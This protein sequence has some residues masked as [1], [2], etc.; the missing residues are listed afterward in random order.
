MNKI[1]EKYITDGYKVRWEYIETIP[2]FVKLKDC[3]QNP[4]WHS[5][6]TAWDHTQACVSAAYTL[7]DNEYKALTDI[8]KRVLLTSVLF[9]DIGKGETTEFTK[10]NWHSYGHEII[11][12][13]VAR[14][15]LWEE[16]FG[17]RER[18][19]AMVRWHMEVLRVAESKDY[20]TK[21][22]KMSCNFFF[23][24]RSAIFVKKCDS[25]GS[26][27]DDNSVS[28][29]D[30]AKLDFLK[31]ACILLNCYEQRLFSTID[32]RKL[33]GKQVDWANV[34]APD[35][36]KPEIYMLVGLPG[37]G[38]NT[39]IEKF[40]YGDN[41]VI[42]CRD[43]IRVELGFCED[44][45]KIIGTHEQEDEV[46]KIFNARLQNAVREGKTVIINNINLRKSYRDSYHKLV[47]SINSNVKWV[48]VYVEA[49]TLE[50]N[51]ARRE[52]QISP[53][54]YKGMIEKFDWPTADE[55]DELII[56]K[57]NQ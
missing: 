47:D 25:L 31:H 36:K 18:V 19:C 21:L 13:R 51:F 24:W 30:Q 16:E 20:V 34:A 3:Q 26:T 46:T 1:F 12:E 56:Q 29:A 45:E 27:P 49:P 50:S 32:R 4:K 2:E 48:Y 22:L 35:G 9:H 52:G 39:F 38:K 8:D 6:G 41:V 37:A 23:D 57:Q 28:V 7:L 5:E 40:F 44:G 53:S 54:A 11:G 10:G 33:F 55:Y 42:I 43:D 17:L 14:R 15:I